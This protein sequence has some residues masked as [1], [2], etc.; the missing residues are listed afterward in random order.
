MSPSDL[1]TNPGD[2]A[3]RGKHDRGQAHGLLLRGNLGFGVV[4][5]IINFDVRACKEEGVELQ[6]D[7][8]SAFSIDYYRSHLEIMNSITWWVVDRPRDSRDVQDG[9]P[10]VQHGSRDVQVLKI[11]RRIQSLINPHLC[12]FVLS[13]I[14][15][16]RLGMQTAVP[17]EMAALPSML[18]YFMKHIQP[19]SEGT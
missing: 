18:S 16:F 5:P 3:H 11:P 14:Q 2:H 17:P 15:G 7:R 9:S 19:R 13:S 1:A 4:L 10:T 8:N 6:R 12:A